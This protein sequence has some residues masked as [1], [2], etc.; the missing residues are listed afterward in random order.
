MTIRPLSRLGVWCVLATLPLG[1]EAVPAWEIAIAASSGALSLLLTA[2]AVFVCY[3]TRTTES[4]VR[5]TVK[6]VAAKGKEA[7]QVA[8]SAGGDL[9]KTVHDATKGGTLRAAGEIVGTMRDTVKATPA[10]AGELLGAVKQG[11]MQTIAAP[12]EANRPSQAGRAAVVP[13]N[14]GAPRSSLAGTAPGEANRPSQAGRAAVVP[15]NRGAPRSSLAGTAPRAVPNTA[16]PVAPQRE[17]WR[18]GSSVG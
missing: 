2:Y 10:A 13:T 7:V 3:K 9:K 12:G 4:P 5:D 6:T 8:V 16:A 14:R 11:V 17:V 18:N 15:T 1:V